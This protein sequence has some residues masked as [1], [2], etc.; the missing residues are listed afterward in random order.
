MLSTVVSYA[1][2][3]APEHHIELPFSHWGFGGIALALFAFMLA[4]LWSFRGTA[5]K[6]SDHEGHVVHGDHDV[7]RTAHG[8]P[9]QDRH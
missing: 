2:E 1:A 7:P 3:A 5:N 4:A 8:D 9:G 6:V